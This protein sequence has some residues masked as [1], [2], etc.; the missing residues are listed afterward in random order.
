MNN[1]VEK[2]FYLEK[3][4]ASIMNY[5]YQAQIKALGEFQF[6][7]NRNC[8]KFRFNLLNLIKLISD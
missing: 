1:I 2:I 4:Y 7:R 5:V 8:I 6:H 3:L